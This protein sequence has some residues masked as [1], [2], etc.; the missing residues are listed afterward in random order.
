MLNYAVKLEYLPKNPLFKVG[1]FKDVLATKNEVGF[2]T[3]DEFRAFITVAKEC[4]LVK[5]TE[6][7][8]LYE[9]NYH[10]FFN[11][12]FYTGL[13]KGEINALRW[14]DLEGD[15]L[16]VKHSISQKLHNQDIE[17]PPKNKSSIRTLQ[18]PI[19]LITILNE[20]KKRKQLLASFSDNDRILGNGKCIRDTSLQNRN[21]K[22]AKLA[23]MKKIRIHDFRHSHA[24]LLANMGINIQEVARRLGH[25]RIEMTWNTYSHLYPRAEEK[26]MEVLNMV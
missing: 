14:S 26:A 12:A 9:W 10:V 24:S 2:Y 7:N 25:T 1:N 15:Y 22:Y 21:I 11:I 18:M 8:D 4:A 20:H 5:Q 13:R 16:L 23:G 6:K 19:P 3:P 17:T